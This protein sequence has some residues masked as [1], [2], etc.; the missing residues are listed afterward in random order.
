MF[1]KSLKTDHG[2]ENSFCSIA[3][4]LRLVKRQH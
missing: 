1:S 4:Y 2:D 3:A